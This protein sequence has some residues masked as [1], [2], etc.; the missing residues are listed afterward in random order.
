MT[1]SYCYLCRFGWSFL[2][3]CI[4]AFALTASVDPYCVFGVR[5]IAG[6]NRLKPDAY[7][8][9]AAAKTYLLERAAPTTLLLGNSRIDVGFDP[10]SEQWPKTM[11]PVFN[12][13]L[14]GRDLSIA[15]KILDGALAAPGLKH[16]LVGIDLP[17]FLRVD[18][19]VAPAGPPDPGT[20]GDRLSTTADLSSD[21]RRLFARARDILEATL[22]IDSVSDS[23]TTILAQHRTD[24]NTMTSL[25]FNPLDDYR[26]YVRLH[27]FRDLFD[28]KQ[29]SYVVGFPTNNAH[30][31]YT[32]PYAAPSFRSL[33]QIIRTARA[34]D[35]EVTLIIYPYH[36]WFMDLVRKDGLWDAFDAARR[37]LVAVVAENDPSGQVRIIDFSGYNVYTTEPVPPP[38]D[39]RDEV[40]WYWEPGH[41]RP[42]LG[43]L[44]IARTYRDED[45][46]FGRNLTPSTIENVLAA[47]RVEAMAEERTPSRN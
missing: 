16:V 32:N 39:T 5:Q 15:V 27:G 7:H 10:E 36:A 21:V 40:R 20:D 34:H 4:V 17:E 47:M 45:V 12:A 37:T 23:F 1:P 30:P 18:T 29:A 28:Q 31:D 13:G 8:R 43:D 25:G 42:S 33:R 44:I 35:I 6:W 24:T 2:A 19:G 9:A 14:D 3:F 46:G 11:R 38:G 22:T 26:A 41:F